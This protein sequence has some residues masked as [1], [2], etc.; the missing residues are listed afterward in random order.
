MLQPDLKTFFW[1]LPFRSFPLSR[2]F[3]EA[4][5]APSE[6]MSLFLRQNKRMGKR[7]YEK[8]WEGKML[9]RQGLHRYFSWSKGSDGIFHFPL[10]SEICRW[11]KASTDGVDWQKTGVQERQGKGRDG[12]GKE[13]IET[14]S[15]AGKETHTNTNYMESWQAAFKGSD[16]GL[17]EQTS[18]M[19]VYGK[20]IGSC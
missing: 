13:M 1:N 20:G 4:I 11:E 5:H 6:F 12:I 18:G 19:A 8:F 15:D 17:P 10:T 14:E 7:K 16:N 2:L 9:G 3:F